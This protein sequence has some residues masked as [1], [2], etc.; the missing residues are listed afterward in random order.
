MDRRVNGR[1]FE[2]FDDLRLC[3][4]YDED[5]KKDLG[6]FFFGVGPLEI[7]SGMN[8]LK[9]D[10]NDFVWII[11]GRKNGKNQFTLRFRRV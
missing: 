4:G 3:L 11:I 7:L 6:H 9:K 5:L 10:L 2:G 1:G 8:D